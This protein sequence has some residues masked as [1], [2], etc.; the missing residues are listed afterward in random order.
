MAKT[1]DELKSAAAVVRDATEE[2]ENTA[3]RVGTVLIDMIDT[4]S[5]SVSINAIKGYVVI[6]STSELPENPTPEQQQKG[7]LLDTTL[8][9][10][11]GEGGDTLDGKYQSAQLKGTKGDKGDKGNSGVSLGDV[12]LVNDLTTGG[13]D[14]A[15]T[16]EMGKELGIQV[17]GGSRYYGAET[18]PAS[19]TALT[20]I[21]QGYQLK[22][23]TAGTSL[24]NVQKYGSST[25]RNARVPVEGAKYVLYN[26]YQSGSGY[27][28]M[29]VDANDVVLS[30]KAK[31]SSDPNPIFLT[32]PANAKYF[33]YSYSTGN[34]A[35]FNHI[36]VYYE[37]NA[38]KAGL[39]RVIRLVGAGEVMTVSQTIKTVQRGHTYKVYVKH[40]DIAMDEV[41]ST[42]YYRLFGAI[43]KD[44]TNYGDYAFAVPRASDIASEYTVTIPDESGDFALKIGMRANDGA[45]Q[46]FCIE[47]VTAIMENNEQSNVVIARG[48]GDTV[49]RVTTAASSGHTYRI[50][51]MNPS[52]DMSGVTYTSNSYVRL[53][54]AAVI[55]NTT[56]DL[57]DV[58]VTAPLNDYYYVRI[59][60]TENSVTLRISMRATA[61]AEQMYVIEDVTDEVYKDWQRFLAG[62]KLEIGFFELGK[63]FDWYGTAYN[64]QIT[65]DGNNLYYEGS[66]YTVWAFSIPLDDIGSIKLRQ[67]GSTSQYGS[68]LLDANNNFQYIECNNLSTYASYVKPVIEA[69]KT[70]LF[71]QFYPYISGRN[72]PQVILYPKGYTD[73]KIEDVDKRIGKDVVCDSLTIDYN[74]DPHLSLYRLGGSTG[75]KVS[76]V[77]LG[78]TNYVN[79]II[80]GYQ[81]LQPDGMVHFV[82][83]CAGFNRL[84]ARAYKTYSDY[85]YGLYLDAS[86]NIIK[87]LY[88]T[89]TASAIVESEVPSNAKYFIY[90]VHQSYLSSET[91]NVHVELISDGI[92]KEIDSLDRRLDEVGGNS[93]TDLSLMLGSLDDNGVIEDSQNRAVSTF[94]SH[95]RGFYIELADGYEVEKA[96]MYDTAGN[97]VNKRYYSHKDND[98]TCWGSA[99][100]MPQFMVRVVVKRSDDGDITS[101]DNIV[102][103]FLYLDDK[104]MVRTVPETPNF[105]IMHKRIGQLNKMVWRPDGK[106]QYISAN[107]SYYFVNG[108]WIGTPYSEVGEYTKYLGMHVA[109]RTYLTAAMNKRSVLYTENV[110]AA[111]NASKYGLT[112]HC[113]GDASGTYYGTVCSGLTAYVSNLKD[114]I[115]ADTSATGE[116]LAQGQ[117]DV[118]T[119]VSTIQIKRNGSFVDATIDELF[120]IIEPMDFIWN[121]GHISIISDVYKDEY[122]KKQ[123]MVWTEEVSPCGRSTPYSRKTLKQR[124]DA[125]VNQLRNDT[126]KQWGIYRKSDSYWSA[127]AEPAEDTSMYIQDF[128]GDYPLEHEIDKDISTFAGEYAAF[129]IGDASDTENNNKAF[130]NIHRDNKYDTLQIFAESADESTD[131]P[132]AEV[133]IASNSGT[134]IYNSTNIYA[135]DASDADDWIVVDLTQLST[136]L[137]YGKYKARVIDSSDSSVV[138]GFTHFEMVDITFSINHTAG[139]TTVGTATFSSNEGTPY[140]IRQEKQDGMQTQAMELSSS[141][142]ESGSKSI[143]WSLSSRYKYIKLFVRGD[144]GVVVK[145]I[146]VVDE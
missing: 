66:S 34:A 83:D 98:S 40:T 81:Y 109:F 74:T 94:I 112:H 138:S 87:C 12:V 68:A 16:A 91:A 45:E 130:L 57:L 134:F 17:N 69:S 142:V 86:L 93:S 1:I 4:L 101:T 13:D 115:Y 107:S 19:L 90:E 135:S 79:N 8:Y 36:S 78:V 140:L 62:E 111:N 145:R 2:K 117:I 65:R 80:K 102:R 100:A 20:H 32:V 3:M 132:V 75:V 26:S 88:H 106:V 56:V 120:D 73:K 10:Y 38:N 27:G 92:S 129:S 105:D 58:S 22:V 24:D 95:G 18:D 118:S 104:R 33:I 15:L 131:S 25:Y 47:D 127:N 6:D 64:K 14:N 61:G 84:K 49:V 11:V 52:I 113:L 23:P 44:G 39:T 136:P 35:T 125:I 51:L 5:E 141:D 43:Q 29:F 133:S 71:S 70:L 123:I 54:A 97:L 124:F 119:G 99:S 59:P 31:T 67:Y 48:K 30:G 41:V 89:G 121:S 116:K 126:N 55:E 128:F 85:T 114:I 50:N 72:T 28:S 63:Y 9:V 82:V 143:T 110:S 42:A 96:M 137:T 139:S 37:S 122:G 144:Y 77:T 108:T 46:I 146:I 7:Y 76:D 21:Y 60:T 53:A 103:K